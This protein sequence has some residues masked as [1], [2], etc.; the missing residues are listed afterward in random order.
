MS[1]K[2][3]EIEK[4]WQKYWLDSKNFEPSNNFT[5]QKKYIVSMFPYPSGK[6]HMG[7]V[8]NYA[9]SDAMAR[10]YRRQG[11]NVFHPFGWDAFGLPA[12]N[13]AIKNNIHPK[14]WTYENIKN[15]DAELKRLGLSFAWDQECIT[16]D[17][18]YTKWEQFLFIQLWNK[19][20]IYK[21]KSLLNWCEND[22]TV[23]ANE[24][25]VD[26][27]CWRCNENVVQKEMD[28]YYLKITEYADELLNDLKTLEN[29]WPQQVLTMQKNWIGRE[30][31]YKI[32][33]ESANK[34]FEIV[35]FE[36]DYQNIVNADF[37]A[38]NF[39]HPLVKKLKNQGFLNEK[40]QKILDEINNCVINKIFGKKLSIKTPFQVINPVT[41]DFLDVYITDFASFSAKEAQFASSKNESHL[42]FMNANSISVKNKIKNYVV[43]EKELKKVVQYNLRDW[44]ISRQRYWGTPIPLIHCQM[45]GTI[46]VPELDLPILLPEKVEFTGKGNPILT[47][48]EWVKTKC[49]RCGMGAKRETDTLDTF[50]E[51]SWYWMRYTTPQKQRNNNLFIKENLNY[52][53]QVD[54]YIGGIEHAILHL[55]YARF[56]S[57]ALADLGL[58]NYREPFLNLLTQGMVLKDGAKMSKSKGNVVEP[59]EMIE[60]YGA[61]AT[62]LF[63]F[64]AAPPAKELD[65][66]DAGLNGCFKFLNRLSDRINELPENTTLDEINI[67]KLSSQEKN[68]RRKLYQGMQ[69]YLDV[70]NKRENEYA[71]N[72]VIAWVMETFNEYDTI[73]DVALLKEMYYV[74]LNILEPFAPHLAWEYSEK[75]FNLR[76]LDDFSIDESALIVNELSYG[77]T[78]NGK[79]RGEILVDI[80]SSE[81]EVIE[82]AQKEVTKWLE[83]KQIIKKIFIPKKLINFV[84]K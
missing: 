79:V 71:F 53:N 5:L 64:F 30:E 19:G 65:W 40:K 66:S 56:F 33:L 55:L 81:S 43:L 51:S 49:Y 21:K 41:H 44:G 78:V 73:K 67:E 82:K 2:F 38:I 45:C 8:K 24:Q 29:H 23:L 77:I 75:Y 17:A 6:I 15:M 35:V 50:F 54:E 60:K 83:G 76:N 84:I 46:P 27:K 11:F 52:W 3:E 57:K 13:A 42:S 26:N 61:D 31:V 22:N 63:V 16:A 58:I 18:T 12:E 48:N 68:A 14:K 25:V 10:F 59:K 28:T 1:Y 7:H 9:I 37:L 32:I 62:R 74:V 36:K 80:N 20:L 70:F 39:K 69:K 4:K 34:D 47:N 72:T